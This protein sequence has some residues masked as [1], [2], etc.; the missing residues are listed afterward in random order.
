M[1]KTSCHNST[2][3]PRETSRTNTGAHRVPKQSICIPKAINSTLPLAIRSMILATLK[4]DLTNTT[5][6]I[7][8]II[9]RIFYTILELLLNLTL[10]L[11]VLTCPAIQYPIKVISILVIWKIILLMPPIYA[12]LIVRHRQKREVHDS[13]FVRAFPKHNIILA[14][15]MLITWWLHLMYV[16][17]HY[18]IHTGVIEQIY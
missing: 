2:S 13:L 4:W 12:E 15:Y 10:F 18:V 9:L 11:M 17:G 8:R 5:H 16:L 3:M 7:M 6:G 1:S 14:Y